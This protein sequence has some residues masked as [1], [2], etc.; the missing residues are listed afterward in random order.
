MLFSADFR[1]L[2]L[3][4]LISHRTRFGE[5]LGAQN[6]MDEDSCSI[7]RMRSHQMVDWGWHPRRV[8]ADPVPSRQYTLS[9]GG[10]QNKPQST[11]LCACIRIL[12]KHL[13]QSCLFLILSS[14]IGTM[15]RRTNGR[16]L[17]SRKDREAD[18]SRDSTTGWRLVVWSRGLQWPN[19]GANYEDSDR[20]ITWPWLPKGEFQLVHR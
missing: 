12:P 19:C 13:E 3:V 5:H 11:K 8:G 14:S 15:I 1:S 2:E 7:H 9:Q 10:C 18:R 6:S 17:L 4:T 20:N 16:Y